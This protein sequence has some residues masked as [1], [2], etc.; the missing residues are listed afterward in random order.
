MAQRV[1]SEI[2]DRIERARERL[3]AG[4]R[5]IAPGERFDDAAEHP[6][7]RAAQRRC[8]IARPL[9]RGSFE[10]AVRGL[11]C[12]VLA[13]GI[14]APA[15]ELPLHDARRLRQR[16]ELELAEAVRRADAA[17]RFENGGSDL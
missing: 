15:A 11:T 14:D 12:A 10:N 6:L 1:D 5:R 4:S 8:G 7:D 13:N 17:A 9:G 2:E 3:A 16:A